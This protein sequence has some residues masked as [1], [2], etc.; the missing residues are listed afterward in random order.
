MTTNTVKITPIEDVALEGI[1]PEVQRIIGSDDPTHIDTIVPMLV[2][3]SF[4]VY[5]L[6]RDALKNHFKGRF[7][8]PHLDKAM[9]DYR[10]KQSRA[11]LDAKRKASALPVIVIGTEHLRDH[12]QQ[13]LDSLAAWNTP[14]QIYIQS[15]R[16]VTIIMDEKK[17][18]SIGEVGV[19]RM[20][21]FMSKAADYVNIYH[22]SEG[23][24]ETRAYPPV[25][26]VKGILEGHSPHELP[27]PPLKGITELPI[28][29]DDGTICQT[30]GYDVATG[31]VYIPGD[32]IIP[33]I[34]LTPTNDEIEKAKQLINEWLKN[35]PFADDAS[36]AAII[37]CLITVVVRDIIAG[38]VPLCLMDAPKQ[39][40]GK[41]I[42]AQAIGIVATGK[43]T[44]PNPPTQDEEEMRKRILTWLQQS[45]SVVLIDNIT[46][47]LESS[48][49][50]TVL[51]S[52]TFGDRLLSTN[53][54]ITVENRA[55]WFAS[56]NNLRV[57][58][59]TTRRCF[60][61]R[62]DA[63]MERPHTRKIEGGVN[64]F[65]NWTKDNRAGLIAACLTFYRLWIAQGK[66]S[67]DITPIGSFEE[68]STTIGGILQAVNI[69]DFLA[70][71]DDDGS[72]TI[73]DVSSEWG[74]FFEGIYQTMGSDPFTL[75]KIAKE[76]LN[77]ADDSLNTLLPA[78]L[79][80]S[81]GS[82]RRS[83]GVDRDFPNHIGY[84]FRAKRDQIANGFILKHAGKD[85]TGKVL[86]QIEKVEETPSAAAQGISTEDQE[87]D[88]LFGKVEAFLLIAKE[89]I[90]FSNGDS[91]PPLKLL[92]DI[93]IAMKVV[94]D[95]EKNKRLLLSLLDYASMD[96]ADKNT[97][98]TTPEHK[99]KY[100]EII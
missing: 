2:G 47:V 63:K 80:K 88:Q 83:D 77:D 23:D 29:R 58:D 100:E 36:K 49:L 91:I 65:F 25:D 20:R 43:E 5:G 39:G 9:S 15:G 54:N 55:V 46:H 81:Y 17:T 98:P 78:S 71:L 13:A 57:G 53:T 33:E 51:T 26:V 8:G 68:W 37:A 95:K 48:A 27:F 93:E 61:C 56:G 94:E 97:T 45:P 86:W 44:T 30:S 31:Y 67:P 10:K 11:R 38:Q 50:N 12:D 4:S 28:I 69:S 90:P 7:S 41:T 89:P 92:S 35:F 79:S 24:V 52:P 96:H 99:Y 76:M 75:Q 1:L 19:A 22:S 87:M 34:P 84:A 18:P 66:P 32:L 62:L 59:D 40:T 21:W 74:A 42:L 72:S 85:R 64:R 60:K 16:I 14:P 70:N 3:L 6:Q 73:D 82:Y